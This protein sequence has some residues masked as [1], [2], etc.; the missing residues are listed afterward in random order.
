[1]SLV[2]SFS[3]KI[4]KNQKKK[5]QRKN[6]IISIKNNID[7]LYDLV[8]QITATISKNEHANP[9][10]S[11]G[12]KCFSQSD[13]DGITIEIFKRLKNLNS[14]SFLELGV[15]DGTENNTLILLSLGW[16]G[17]WVGGSDLAFDTSNSKKLKFYKNWI[18]LENIL[19]IINKGLNHL[20]VKE[21]DLISVDLDGNDWL[22]LIIGTIENG[23]LLLANINNKLK[24]KNNFSLNFWKKI[25][26]NCLN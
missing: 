24:A 7:E 17:F 16:N 12:K 14:G 11:F 15:G 8:Y 1:M 22:D 3:E 5:L 20:K 9:L 19:P 25:Y 4:K 2:K 13:E 10:N 26:L 6:S 18:T 23:I 21:L